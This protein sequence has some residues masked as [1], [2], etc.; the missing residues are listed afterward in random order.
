MFPNL[1]LAHSSSTPRFSALSASSS[2]PKHCSF[3]QF[4]L[5]H[6]RLGHASTSVVNSVLNSSNLPS[7]NKVQNF[8]CSSCCL[9][10]THRLPYT[11]SVTV[12]NHPFELVHADVWGPAPI[13]SFNGYSYFVHFI[14]E[15]TKFTWLYLLK[16]KSEVSK[17]FSQFKAMVEVQ[18]NSK[19]KCL[20]T[21]N[22]GEFVALSSL[23]NSSGIQH[24]MSCP[25]TPQ[26][27][28]TAERKNRHIVEL[29]LAMLAHASMPL[30]FWDEAFLTSIH[31]IN[32]LPTPNLNNSSPFSLLYNK[33]PSYSHLRVFGCLCFPNLRPYNKNKFAFKSIHCTLL[34]YSSKH[35]GYRCLGSNGKVYV[36]RDVLFNEKQFPFQSVSTSSTSSILSSL[37]SSPSPPPS[38]PLTSPLYSPFVAPLHSSAVSTDILSPVQPNI[39][40]QVP[41]AAASGVSPTGSLSSSSDSSTRYLLPPPSPLLQHTPVS[42]AH[43]P[44]TSAA[45]PVVN[46]HVMMTRG[47][48]GIFKPRVLSAAVEPASCKVALKD[49]NWRTA[50]EEE[51]TAL[52]KNHT[53]D[54]VPLPPGK[55]PIG[56]KWVFRLKRHPDGTIERY[57][58][59]LVAKGFHQTPGFD[60]SETF[61]PV[62]KPVTIRLV[63]SIALS[64]SWS[65]RQLDINNAF[66]NGHISEDVYMTQPEGFTN[67]DSTLVCKLR[68][69]LYGLRQAPRAWFDTLASTLFSFGFTRAKSDASLFICSTSTYITYVLVYVDDIIVTGSNP[70]HINSLISSLH[71]RFALKDLGDL[72]YFL[73]IQVSKTDSGGLLLTQSKYISDMLTRVNMAAAKPQPT[74]MAA[75]TKLSQFGTDKFDNPKLYRSVVG[76]LQ[77]VCITRPEISF[78]VNKVSQFMHSPLVDH[79]QCVKR[80]LRYLQG[81]STFGLHLQKCSSPRI[82]ALCDADWAA[83]INDRRSTTGFCVYFG[84]NLISWSSK[85]QAVVSRSSTEAE[86]RA[87]ASVVSELCWLQALLSELKLPPSAEPPTIYCDNMSTVMLSANPVL[88]SRM[89]HIELDLFFVREKVQAKMLTVTHISSKDQIADVLTK[90]LPK[91]QFLSLRSKLCVGTLS[92]RGDNRVQDVEENI[93]H[94]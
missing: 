75:G 84:N 23:L 30:K 5:W 51:F 82:T 58:A 54:L 40:L 43:A 35:K 16:H 62:I 42:S 94:N 56:C 31:L 74:P 29:G 12:Y 67:G 59:R 4:N 45:P 38:I 32:R 41:Y 3:D 22:G 57:K 37:S 8:L 66:L 14:D 87:L 6:C 20:Q 85:K 17:I 44:H 64:H 81:T 88:H 10:K 65:I 60:F 63:L 13:E 80:I 69:S 71:N 53:W 24:R 61:S 90:P 73:G 70:Q 1:Q 83:D 9:A 33:S 78:S 50:M 7:F 52:K 79:W 48:K 36:S 21:D 49:H 27:N 18:F 93:H 25:Y 91:P 46:D 55:A 15:H 77:Y 11:K 34:G 28:G 72:H 2:S 26:Q 89:K 47:K 86:Y 76:A 68:K 39:S 19:I 92:L